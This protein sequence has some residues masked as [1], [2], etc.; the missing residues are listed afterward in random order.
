M[1][2]QAS[3]PLNPWLSI[4]FRPRATIRYI[5]DTDPAYRVHLL[6]VLYGLVQGLDSAINRSLGD[7]FPWYGVLLLVLIAGS[8]VGGLL[9]LYVGSAIL[10]WVG[11]KLGG[12]GTFDEVRAAYAW[13]F[14][15]VI[16]GG[17]FFV[18]YF[19][20]F[21]GESFTSATPRVDALMSQ[22][23]AFLFIMIAVGIWMVVGSIVLTIWQLV[24]LSK[25]LAEVH[26]FSAW[27]GFL[28]Y[29]IPGVVFFILLFVILVLPRAIYIGP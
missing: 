18:P 12:R 3:Q 9:N 29:F 2:T 25:T 5:V 14:L 19:L 28:T 23:S 24:I 10:W 7:L 21:R 26:G 8:L 20:I 15:P 16:A 17:I 13:S 27:R 22:S 4:W 11:R 1:E 6:A